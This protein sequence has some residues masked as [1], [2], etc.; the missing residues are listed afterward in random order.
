MNLSKFLHTNSG[1]FISSLLLGLGL[2]SLF[3]KVC[4]DNCIIYKAP[5]HGEIIGNIFEYN[6]K[7]Y[8]FEAIPTTFDKSKR[9]VEFA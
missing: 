4:K 1:R 9:I 7:C 8:I 2:S 5:P 3:K 6:D